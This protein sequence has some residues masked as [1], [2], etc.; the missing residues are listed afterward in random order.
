MW[1]RNTILR[2]TILPLA[3]A[4]AAAATPAVSQ[5]ETYVVVTPPDR[6]YAPPPQYEPVPA[7][8]E[9]YVWTPGYWRDDGDRQVW[10]A[11]HWVAD[12]RYYVRRD[13]DRE[14]EHRW[15]RRHYRDDDD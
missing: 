15:W 10:I 12:G 6:V 14:E 9:G 5:A 11:G 7:A 13:R 8:R 1:T 4:L 3:V 2:R